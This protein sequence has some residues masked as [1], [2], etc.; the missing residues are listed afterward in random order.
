MAKPSR[1]TPKSAPL[2]SRCPKP[3][4]PQFWAPPALGTPILNPSPP[5]SP[6]TLTLFGVSNLFPRAVPAPWQSPS[7]SRTLFTHKKVA[8][9]PKPHPPPF[10]TPP[11]SC[12]ARRG[13]K[14]SPTPIH[15]GFFSPREGQ[16]KGFDPSPLIPGTSSTQNRAHH[17]PTVCVPPPRTSSDPKQRRQQPRGVGFLAFYR[18][19]V[20]CY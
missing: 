3:R 2:G 6:P 11:S 4:T 16:T 5:F 10:P 1:N 19:I 20:F 7:P 17:A 9:R 8:T 13:L 18:F 12:R 14:K 15:V